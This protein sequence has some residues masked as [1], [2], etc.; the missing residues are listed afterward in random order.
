[1][2]TIT[3]TMRFLKKFFS[4]LFFLFIILALWQCGRRG[5]PTGGPKD[6]APPIL[7]KAIPDTLTTYFDA[8]KIRLYF[9]EYIKLKNAQDQMVI[10]PPLKY[11]PLIKPQG[12]PSKY[13]EI[14]FKDTLLK[15]TTYTINFGQSIVDNNEE[16]PNSFLSYVFSTGEHIDSLEIRGAVKDAFNRKVDE[17]IS[18]MLYEI[19]T[20]YTD[21]TIYKNPPRYITNTLDSLPL[22]QL[23]NLKAGDYYLV[24]IKDESKNNLFDQRSDKIGFFKDTISIPTDSLFVLNLFKEIPDY[25][26]SVPS[27]VAKNRIIFGYQGDGED[28]EISELLALPDSVKTKIIKERDK[29]TLNYWLTPT[30]IDSIVFTIANKSQHVIDT[31]TIKTRKLPLDSLVLT[32]SSSG[33]LGFDEKFSILANTPLTKIDTSLITF[34]K[35]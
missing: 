24:A 22:F 20:A 7:V 19:D 13:V 27:Y 21:S 16:N 6:I 34:V 1:L 4:S 26:V 3:L 15:N 30:D 2:P 35:K 8:T 11:R 10:S 31:F 23:K 12:T 33:E 5:T 14:Q 29:D 32:P 9:D 28:I 18:V 25:T 17:F